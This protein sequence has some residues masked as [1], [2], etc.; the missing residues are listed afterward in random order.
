MKMIA[1]V[2]S[3]AVDL[4]VSTPRV[5]I[6]GENFRAHS[7]TIG[8]GGKGA[9]AAAAIARLGADALLVGCV[10]D[11][12]F[13]AMALSAL[14]GYGVD[15]Q[16]VQK[17]ADERTGTAIIMV[18]DN[19]ENT[20]LVIIGANSLLT[21]DR[22]EQ[23][24]ANSWADLDLILVD[25]EIPEEAVAAAV[26]LGREH[27]VPVLVDAGPPRRFHPQ[28]WRAATI[29]S[30]NEAEAAELVG[31]PVEDD[32]SALRAARE[33]LAQGPAA[34]V[35]KR[36]AAGSLLLT[37][38]ET[39]MVPGFKV[40][41]VDTTGAGDAFTAM[42]ALSVAEGLPLRE[43][44]RRGNAAGALAV[45]RWGT[46]AAMPDRAAVESFLAAHGTNETIRQAQEKPMYE[47]KYYQKFSIAQIAQKVRDEGFDPMRIADPPG[48]V[49]SPHT[50]PETKLLAFLQG[51]M[52]VTVQGESYECSPGDKLLIPGNVEHSAIAGPEGCTYFWS[53]KL[54]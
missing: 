42:L 24:L 45:T 3:I 37:R 49:Y 28:T 21:A 11:D 29:I 8:P 34:V 12:D 26:S 30:P 40:D 44:V 41:V 46:M 5:P 17:R 18:D 32:E 48:S 2:G 35:L 22:V 10:G 13:G 52:K 38:D 6:T 16:A 4:T 14:D 15:I 39:V 31:F 36:G 50:H 43:A 53:E 23:S 7:L 27:G 54:V 33:L 25:F 51:T 1:S 19:G 20:I 47:S 9:N